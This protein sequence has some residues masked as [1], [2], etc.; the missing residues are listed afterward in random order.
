MKFEDALY[1]EIY[2]T[3]PGF[4]HVRNAAQERKLLTSENYDLMVE[5]KSR[6]GVQALASQ[7]E[8]QR[9]RVDLLPFVF[10]KGQ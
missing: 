1:S 3:P 7:D 9:V 6:Y 4:S 2:R 10:R 8:W 5:E